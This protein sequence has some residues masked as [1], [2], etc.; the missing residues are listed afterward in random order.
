MKKTLQEE[1]QRFYEIIKEDYQVYHENNEFRDFLGKI[2][3]ELRP[4]NR[5]DGLGYSIYADRVAAALEKKYP[6]LKKLKIDQ[7]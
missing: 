5:N 1:K 6:K 7:K 4:S 2:L 3:W